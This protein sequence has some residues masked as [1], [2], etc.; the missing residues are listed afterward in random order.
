MAVIDQIPHGSFV[1]D[2]G[3]G[4]GLPGIP[5]ALVR[6]DLRITLLESLL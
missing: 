4:A 5:V 2:V 1:I 3:S 6:P